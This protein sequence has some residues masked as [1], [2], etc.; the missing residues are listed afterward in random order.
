MWKLAFDLIL[1]SV[2]AALGAVA[3]YARLIATENGLVRG[4]CTIHWK[5]VMLETP[6]V[7]V[8]GLM[9]GG[10][11]YILGVGEDPMVLAGVA[12]FAGHAGMAVFVGLVLRF[13]EPF[14]P[15]RKPVDKPAD[16]K[17]D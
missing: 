3:R 11:C 4:E 16:P 2:S 12:A 6:G 1:V 8:C 7:I 13:I 14:Y 15:P 9:A 10:L 5:A 17:K